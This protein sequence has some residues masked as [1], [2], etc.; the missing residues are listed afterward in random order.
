M[1]AE[2]ALH[3]A[4]YANRYGAGGSRTQLLL[5]P[6]EPIP[7]E[8]LACDAPQDAFLLAPAFH[9]VS[10]WPFPCA[11]HRAIALQGLLR[12]V[13]PEGR[14]KPREDAFEAVAPFVH[15]GMFAFLSEED[16]GDGDRLAGRLSE[17]AGATVVVTRGANG[18][19]L[20][21][22]GARR[23]FRALPGNPV[24]PTGAGDCFATAFIVRF[25]EINDIDGAMR[26]ALAAGALAVEAPGLAGIPSRAA[27]ERRLEMVAA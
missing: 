19:S 4:R 2:S 1:K 21:R 24:D 14:V 15:R 8:L 25:A 6:G 12:T 18:A 11:R 26:F 7:A 5:E 27:I 23:D 22:A 3:A 17:A 13:D 9:E 10:E 20:Y 16:T